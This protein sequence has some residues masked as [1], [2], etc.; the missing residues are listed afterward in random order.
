DGV[1][2]CG[3]MRKD[4][5]TNRRSVHPLRYAEEHAIVSDSLGI[6]HSDLVE[7]LATYNILRLKV[8]F[9]K[10]SSEF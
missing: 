3:H 1:Y 8:E 9:I 5:C 2:A 7:P 4:D 10:D 6:R